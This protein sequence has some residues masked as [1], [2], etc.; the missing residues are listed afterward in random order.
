MTDDPCDYVKI[1]L[2]S[3]LGRLA[4]ISLRFFN[5]ASTKLNNELNNDEGSL[6]ELHGTSAPD[7]ETVNRII[8]SE[9]N[10]LQESISEIFSNLCDSCDSVRQSLFSEENLALLCEFFGSNKCMFN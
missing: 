2:A 7:A 1:A 3:C 6:S 10:A 4:V 9:K 8:D 5:D